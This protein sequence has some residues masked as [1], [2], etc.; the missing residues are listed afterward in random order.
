MLSR[1]GTF[2][3]FVKVKYQ[4]TKCI[5]VLVVMCIQFIGSTY[6]QPPS[7]SWQK[8]LGGTGGDNANTSQ[9]T[10]DGGYIV[11]G[12]SAS[13][14]G[15]V[16]GNHGGQDVWVVKTD[17]I[18]NIQ[19]QKSLGGTAN[20]I[21]AS[22]QQTSD[23]GY[24]FSATTESNDGDVSGNHGARDF[25]V[26]KLNTT[27]NIQ[28]QK[29][30]GGSQNDRS[31]CIQ[32]T[33]DGGFI[34]SGTVQ[35]TDGD[36]TG[37]HGFYDY[38]IVK[39]DAAGNMQW[40]KTLG[41]SGD[42]NSLSI[43]QTTDAGYITT[44]YSI[45]TN[46]DVTG[47]HGDWDVWLV[48]LNG[49]GNI[50]WQKCLGGINA[51]AGYSVQQT[52]DGG[53]II[54]GFSTSNNGDVTGN[55]GAQDY[56]IIKTDSNGN[57]QWQKSLGG[58]FND[59]ATSI[60]QTTDGNY[61]IAGYTASTDGDITGNHGAQDFWIV[62]LATCTQ[63]PASPAAINGN[64]SP[65]QGATVTYSITDVI[66][67]TGYT[68]T[69]PTGWSIS[70]GQGTISLNVTP[71]N[72]SG[73]ITVTAINNC[74]NSAPQII[75]I[76]VTPLVVPTL[77][78]IANSTSI[79]TGTSVTF[80]ATPA[81][82]GP[83]PVYQW[84]KNG[85]NVG[86]NSTTFIDATLINGDIINCTLTSNASCANPVVVTS[87]NITM[88]VSN[89]I[90]PVVSISSS[91]STICTGAS[92]TF[93]ATAVNGG[94]LPVYQWKKN[95]INVGT[96]S[97]IYIDASL[98]TGDIITCTLTSTASC[99][100][101]ITAV[102]SGIT[103]TV[104]TVVV[105]SVNISTAT[106]SIC[107]G[108][109]AVFSATPINGGTSP[110]YQWKKNSV[111]TGTN[112]STYSDASLNNGDVITCSLTNN[113]GCASPATVT[114]SG[115]TISVTPSVVPNVT[116]TASAT[117]ICAGATV[118]FMATPVNAGASPVYQWQKN[119]VNVGTNSA[120]YSDAI[121][122]NGDIIVCELTS[123]AT[124][125]VPAVVTSSGI[126]IVVNAV[127]SPSVNITAS[128]TTICTGTT[129]TFSAVAFNGGTSPVYQWKK[130]GV[131]VGTN[132]NSYSDGFLSNGDMITCELTS[133]Q[134][135]VTATTSMSNSITITVSTAVVP[136]VNISSTATRICSGDEIVFTATALNAGSNPVYQWKVNN[137]NAGINNPVFT[138][139]GLQHNDRV[140]C[141]ITAS[142]NSCST[143]DFSSNVIAISHYP[144]TNIVI[145]PADT[146]VSLGTQ[147]QFTA[148]V[149]GNI[150]FYEWAP[151]SG[152]VNA[153]TLSPVTI[154]VNQETVYK[155]RVV[156][157]DG[158]DE[159][160]TAIVKVFYDLHI[161]SSFT[162]NKDGLNDVFKPA[163]LVALDYFKLEIYDRSGQLVF[164]STDPG[165]GW[166][167]KVK[168]KDAAIGVYIWQCYYQFRNKSLEYQKGTVTIF[169]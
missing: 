27:G 45:S 145:I 58:S 75:A 141:V 137:I 152:L 41:G 29:C 169:R 16:T 156:S 125:A 97:T 56:W 60:K 66:G 113:D 40:Q 34:V 49:T 94:T 116:I 48:K 121:L 72:N 68:W 101:P 64:T 83:S 103:M 107:S 42:D 149:N 128:A 135:C 95:G 165:N 90:T 88:V 35:S 37:N 98:V 46:G 31:S 85:V 162:P 63:A 36:V 159:E 78:I 102:S 114:S 80:T 160:K 71:G 69:V 2:W 6:S 4:A 122:N 112:N 163:R 151:V 19:W 44:G 127:V 120:N 109:N 77:S 43:R 117:N 99:A 144:V 21:A 111:N 133:N 155:L 123:N 89:V 131:N 52:A 110:T 166:D 9:Q 158:C 70:A 108:V 129:V 17:G 81:N 61:V 100:N 146:M 136:T 3:L 150:Q 84:K 96:N 33:S 92:V 132:V 32:Q 154:P 86:T 167:G 87:M 124:C 26:V 54:A 161:P 55:H 51:E 138:T 1:L 15:D 53:Y 142:V 20:E 11:A 147:I 130:N 24:I 67:A 93:T 105:P 73:N 7:V 153:S 12:V 38:W 157:T 106:T 8:S 115:I 13:N 59:G 91:A 140:H 118:N 119:G 168:G 74:G 65:C 22:I 28:W 139:S 5:L 82:E 143:G 126:T 134:N 18:G 50:Q 104:I 57:I 164:L 10:T 30:L 14:N 25:W 79:C 76:T 62:K 39:L 23:G 148:I 47:N